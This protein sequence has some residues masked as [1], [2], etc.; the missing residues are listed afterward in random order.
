MND[1]S[2]QDDW[3]GDRDLDLDA[4]IDLPD[5]DAV[6]RTRVLERTS[7]QIR[8]R[9]RMRLLAQAAVVLVAFIAGLA[10]MNLFGNRSTGNS[11]D[12]RAV[13]TTPESMVGLPEGVA[14]EMAESTS[15]NPEEPIALSGTQ[16]F[17]S[18]LLRDPEALTFRYNAATPREQLRLLKAAGDYY[19]YTDRNL[20]LAAKFYRRYIEGLGTDFDSLFID[21]GNWLFASISTA[22][23]E[24]IQNE[25]P[26]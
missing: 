20:D 10:T 15:A 6:F 13:S 19:F 9:R 25:T 11:P 18:E 26:S 17:P 24:D 8:S 16:E 23:Q 5:P 14:I 12:L 3:F 2:Q 21:T 4:A 22:V 7:G 1:D